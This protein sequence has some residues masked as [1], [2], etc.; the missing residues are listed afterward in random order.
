MRVQ[1]E[2][3]ASESGQRTGRTERRQVPALSRDLQH[4]AF[5]HD[6]HR[7]IGRLLVKTG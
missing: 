5:A 6:H 1:R 4:F 3:V 7:G 2:S